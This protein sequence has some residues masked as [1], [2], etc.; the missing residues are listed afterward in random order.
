M[1]LPA[2][3]LTILLSVFAGYLAGLGRRLEV[4]MLVRDWFFILAFCGAL[5]CA[6]VILVR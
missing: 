2:I 6:A 4:P 3:I 1:L 5:G